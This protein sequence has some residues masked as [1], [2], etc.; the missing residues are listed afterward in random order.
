MKSSP[1]ILADSLIDLS[2]FSSKSVSATKLSEVREVSG[3][4]ET[5]G[6]G[7]QLVYNQSI[8]KWVIKYWSP[9][10]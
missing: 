9:Y 8:D 10:D 4:E 2:N 6:S 1:R 5:I 7:A 3:T